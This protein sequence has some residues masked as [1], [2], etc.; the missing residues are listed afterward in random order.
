LGH[1]PEQTDDLKRQ[2]LAA[3]NDPQCNGNIYLVGGSA[4]G[5]LVLWCGLDPTTGAV[6]GWDETARAHIKGVVSLSGPADFCDWSP[7]NNIP[8]N[9]LTVFEN[10]LDNYVGL[11]DQTKCTDN[12]GSLLEDASPVWL[13]TN[14]ATS[15]PPPIMLYTTVGDHVP[16]YD[17]DDMFTAL[18]THYGTTGHDFEKWK[19]SY[20]Y[21]SGY[22]HAFHYWHAVNDDPLSDGA[23]VSEEVINFLESH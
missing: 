21:A 16:Y 9:K 2:I 12:M 15:N 22:E 19:M 23:C 7:D 10:D 11:D 4:G 6:T 14:G 1:A 13:V 20:I 18:I 5:T 8:S 17:A 3:I